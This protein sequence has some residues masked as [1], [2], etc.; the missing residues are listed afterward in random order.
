MFDLSPEKVVVI[1]VIALVVLGPNRVADTA[2]A[3]GRARARLR[4]LS[5]ELPPGTAK[6]IQNPRGAIFDAL[7]EPRQTIAGTAAAAKESLTPTAEQE[8]GEGRP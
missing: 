3:L 5:S 4:Q 1:L 6:L 2:R 8:P 7:A